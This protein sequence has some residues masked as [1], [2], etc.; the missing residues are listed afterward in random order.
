L[1]ILVKKRLISLFLLCVFAII[2]AHSVIPHTHADDYSHY[3][4]VVHGDDD[5]HYDLLQNPLSH[6]FSHFQHDQGNTV[7]YESS[8]VDAQ[9]SKVQLDAASFRFMQLVIQTVF[10]EPLKHSEYYSN[11]FI[12]YHYSV[13]QTLRGP[14]ASQ[15]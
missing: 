9:I 14:P 11:P 7:I 3:G 1:I 15:A 2:F 4:T 13:T 8:S 10:S 6:A 5:N 12:R